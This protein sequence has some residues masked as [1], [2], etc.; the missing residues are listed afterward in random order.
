MEKERAG[1]SRTARLFYFCFSPAAFSPHGVFPAPGLGRRAFSVQVPTVRRRR[2]ADGACASRRLFFTVFGGVPA[3]PKSGFREIRRV[4]P[5]NRC[6]DEPVRRQAGTA[7]R[8][9]RASPF[10]RRA[11]PPGRFV[12]G[13]VRRRSGVGCCAK[14]GLSRFSA[15]PPFR[16]CVTIFR[17]SAPVLPPSTGAGR[18]CGRSR[19]W[20]HPFSAR[21][22]P[23]GSF[24]AH[25][26]P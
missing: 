25:R 10:P 23:P 6:V 21:C 7:L 1:S 4:P 19:L 26:P 17:A 24:P 11:D 8:G 15:G 13:S 22:P 16:L 20:S 12:A 2:F 3:Q 9:V 5:M 14:A 18:W